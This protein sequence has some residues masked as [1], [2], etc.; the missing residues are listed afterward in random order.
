MSVSLT[1]PR[2]SIQQLQSNGGNNPLTQNIN[3]P[4]S[5]LPQINPTVSNQTEELFQKADVLMFKERKFTEAEQLYK[6]ILDIDPTSVEALNSLGNCI[7]FQSNINPDL[8]VQLNDKLLEIYQ[9]ALLIDPEDIEANFNMGLLHL[10]NKNQDLQKAL[11]FFLKSIEHDVT[12]KQSPNKDV[13]KLQQINKSFDNSQS[14]PTSIAQQNLQISYQNQIQDLF[15]PQFAKAY[16]NIGMIYDRLGQ[17]PLASKYYKKCIQKFEALPNT[18]DNVANN[19]NSE[20]QRLSL[21][22]S[23]IY[24][25]AITNFAVTLEKIGKRSESIKLLEQLQQVNNQTQGE[26]RIMNNLGILEKR[27]GNNDKAQK[28]FQNALDIFKI[29]KNEGNSQQNYDSQKDLPADSPQLKSMNSTS[30]N[31][32]QFFPN[33]NMGVYKASL[34]DQPNQNN[35]IND[36][37]ALKYFKKAL[38]FA[39]A[40]NE[41]V[42]QINVLINMSIIYERQNQIDKAIDVLTQVLQINNNIKS[43]QQR[44][45]ALLLLKVKQNYQPKNDFSE[46]KEKLDLTGQK[47]KKDVSDTQ[48]QENSSQNQQQQQYQSTQQFNTEQAKVQASIVQEVQPHKQSQNSKSTKKASDLRKSQDQISQSSKL[49][50]QQQQKLKQSI[51]QNNYE[52]NSQKSI[53]SGTEETA[54]KNMQRMGTGHGGVGIQQNVDIMRETMNSRASLRS[55]TQQITNPNNKSIDHARLSQDMSKILL[56]NPK[57]QD[58]DELYDKD[59]D[60]QNF[61]V[62]V[63]AGQGDQNFLKQSL[64]SLSQNTKNIAHAQNIQDD[65]VHDDNVNLHEQQQEEYE[66]IQDDRKIDEEGINSVMYRTQASVF[67]EAN[68]SQIIEHTQSQIDDQGDDEDQKENTIIVDQDTILHL[69][70]QMDDMSQNPTP[71]QQTA[72]FKNIKGNK[73][74]SDDK[75]EDQKTINIDK[76]DLQANDEEEEDKQQQDQTTNLQQKLARLNSQHSKMSTTYM[77]EGFLT[78]SRAQ[79]MERLAINPNDLRVIFRLGIIEL[80]EQNYQEA[81]DRFHEVVKANQENEDNQE[82]TDG[83]FMKV[84]VC[85]K[86]GETYYKMEKCLEAHEWFVKAEEAIKPKEDYLIELFKAKSL[87]KIRK[88]EDAILSYQRSLQLYENEDDQEPQLLGNIQFRLGWAYIRSRMN[89]GKG[90]QYLTQAQQNIPNN[91]EINIKLAG[92]LFREENKYAEALEYINKA[93]EIQADN[94]DSQLLKGKILDRLERHLEAAEVFNKVLEQQQTQQK[95]QQEQKISQ[96]QSQITNQM[97]ANSVFYLGQTYER[98]KD[99]KKC[100]AL[101]KKCLTIDSKNLG[102]CVHLANL[103]ASIGEGERALKYFKHALKQEPESISVNYGIA[104]TIQQFQ[105]QNKQQAITHYEF[106]IGKEPD[107]FRSLTQLGMLY[108]EQQN[109]EKAA[110]MLKQAITV[111]KQYGVAL[112]TMG[113]LLFETGQSSDSL[114]Y[115]KHAL[116]QNEKDVQALIGLGNA[117][118][119]LKNMKRAIGFYQRVLEID[120]KQADVHYNLGNALFLSGEVEQSVVHYQKA[121]EQNPQKSE[122]YYNLGNA[123]CGKSDYIQAVDAYQKTLDLSPQNG[124]ALYNMGNAY[125]MQGKTR[126]AIDTYSKAIEINDKSAETFF[127]IASAYNDVGEIDHAIKHYQK[128]I[129]L[130]PENSDTY[131][132]LAQIYEKNKQ[133]E[134]AEKCYKSILALEPTNQKATQALTKLTNSNKPVKR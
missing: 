42:Y 126:E 70:P 72:S 17:I 102:A 68:N 128:A 64:K 10:Q 92:V 105:P 27:S 25:K 106:I 98:M 22:K 1:N 90:I 39:K 53:I 51:S 29:S 20:S 96:D 58:G 100:A 77:E 65:K 55:M 37:Q 44:L 120:Q 35:E 83:G 21:M 118:Y 104:K 115:Y 54:V 67:K 103:L 134:M 121:I 23:P 81:L 5:L 62:A 31:L 89:L 110:E 15:R 33:Y 97:V 111:N 3:V 2:K 71:L 94:I 116:A 16:F 52:N 119:D 32:E 60:D 8:K 46:K 11:Q 91:L 108:L 4:G 38:E 124:P 127:N 47:L 6:E 74:L 114:K 7:R 87:D 50:T 123:L 125:Y 132:C 9:R 95:M 99:Y 41:V 59:I 34:H 36:G 75:D 133:V 107:H 76:T 113:N 63:D 12:I 61:F 56:E 43:A 117:H 13:K 49:Q 69:E 109:Y 40:S 101:Y 19:N 66:E 73:K 129:D 122:A 78:W 86:M 18:L 85:M 80:S 130:D 131:F 28:Y 93:L 57:M 79:C 30:T 84:H 14:N 24:I 112:V 82:Q 26:V 48:I 88:F 45:D